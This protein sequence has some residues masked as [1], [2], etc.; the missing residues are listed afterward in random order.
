M[1]IEHIV[2]LWTELL[3]DGDQKHTF[4]CDA[5]GC[6]WA[7]RTDEATHAGAQVA[8]LQ[9]QELM[10]L[11]ED[12]TEL[13]EALNKADAK[14]EDCSSKLSGLRRAY[15]HACAQRDKYQRR[16]TE[17]RSAALNNRFRQDVDWLI[18]EVGWPHV[19]ECDHD[20][21]ECYVCDGVKEIKERMKVIDDD[22]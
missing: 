19:Q 8:A 21:G 17:W 20:E 22:S 9:H 11:R 7:I 4:E 6:G 2:K 18:S 12:K 10:Q 5:E 14:Y 3:T 15:D 16:T 1:T 13:I